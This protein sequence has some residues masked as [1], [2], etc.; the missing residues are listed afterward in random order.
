MHDKVHV[1]RTMIATIFTAVVTADS[2]N[3]LTKRITSRGDSNSRSSAVGRTLYTDRFFCMITSTASLTE[4]SK[5]QD[6]YQ[7]PSLCDFDHFDDLFV[8]FTIDSGVFRVKKKIATR[9]SLLLAALARIAFAC[10]RHA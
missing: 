1:S 5:F 3:L 8:E 2:R 9:S 4:A 7:L 6:T 10:S